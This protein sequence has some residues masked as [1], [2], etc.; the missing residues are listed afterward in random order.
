MRTH[1]QSPKIR[2]VKC[3]V[4]LI[5]IGSTRAHNTAATMHRGEGVLGSSGSRNNAV[6]AAAA[7]M[8]QSAKYRSSLAGAGD[9]VM[10][11]S[12]KCRAGRPAKRATSTWRHRNVEERQPAYAYVRAR[13]R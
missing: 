4:P 10:S 7:A 9:V 1:K 8:R 3:D 13:T 12:E 11:K 5:E 2:P 6:R